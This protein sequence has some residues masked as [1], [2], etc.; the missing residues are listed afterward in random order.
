MT[1]KGIP[2]IAIVF[3]RRSRR[4]TKLFPRPRS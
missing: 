1:A 4:Q 2:Y 3:D